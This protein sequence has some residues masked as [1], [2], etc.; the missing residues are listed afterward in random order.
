MEIR[1]VEVTDASEWLRMRMA[2]FDE[3]SIED[4][5]KEIH[6]FLACQ[7][8]SPSPN[9]HAAFVCPRSGDKLCG[10]I[11]VSIRPYADGCETTN[12]GYLEAWYVDEDSRGRGVG[13]ALVLAAEV[14]ASEQGCREMASDADL[15]NVDSQRAHVRL[16]YQEV[17]RVVQYCKPVS[18]LPTRTGEL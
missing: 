14:W 7:P 16:G 4:E 8:G 5:A 17:G 15:T 9:L 10:L 2:L 3:S 12:V 1:P 18:P 11:E 6:R 13:R